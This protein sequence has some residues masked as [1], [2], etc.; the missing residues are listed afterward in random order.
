VSRAVRAPSRIDTEFF[1]P[2]Q[3]PFLLAGG[4]S[5]RSEISEVFE[6]GYRTQPSP[7]SSL[8]ISVFHNVHDHLRNLE[9]GPGGAFVLANTIEGETTG[10]EAWGSYRATEWWRLSAGAVLLDQDLRLEAGSAGASDVS[11]AGNDPEYQWL[12]RS[13][14]D[15][16]WRAA[17]DIG[18]RRVGPLPDPE[19]PGYTAVDARVAWLPLSGVEL[20]LTGQNL[21]DARHPEFGAAPGQSHIERSLYLKLLWSF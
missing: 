14:F 1:V 11:V 6:L 18:V 19:V 12:L 15:L 20:S 8:S 4:P 13:S 9:P 7:N 5:F 16:P 21:F 10:V 17:L 2:G 3:A